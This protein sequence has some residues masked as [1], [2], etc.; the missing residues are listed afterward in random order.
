MAEKSEEDF[1]KETSKK[2]K[3]NIEK[4][5]TEPSTSKLKEKTVTV[6]KNVTSM[7]DFVSCAPS[8]GRHVLPEDS[9]EPSAHCSSTKGKHK[10][11]TRKWNLNDPCT[12]E[13]GSELSLI[14]YARESE[15][16][17]ISG[18]SI[19]LYANCSESD[20]EPSTQLFKTTNRLKIKKAVNI[21]NTRSVHIDFS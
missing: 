9:P 14:N 19:L 2:S 5:Y 20:S 10:I 17:T 16:T 3:E 18:S 1:H 13:D 12:S 7:K 4:S 8:K 21:F 6:P 15:S 11:S